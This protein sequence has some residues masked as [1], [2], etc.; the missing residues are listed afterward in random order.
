MAQ[1]SEQDTLY[2]R[3]KDEVGEESKGSAS[4]EDEIDKGEGEIDR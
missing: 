3:V 1:R 2:S 4:T